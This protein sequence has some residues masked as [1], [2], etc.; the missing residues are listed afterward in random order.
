MNQSE[1][2]T[3]FGRSLRLAGGDL[4]LVDGGFAMVSGQDN[5]LQALQIMIETPFGTD[6]FNINHGFDLLASVSLRPRQPASDGES[7]EH[8]T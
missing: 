1:T 4:R 7:N 3:V 2:P 6:I 5:F 8:A